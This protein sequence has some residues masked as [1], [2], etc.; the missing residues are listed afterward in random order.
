MKHNEKGINMNVK[1]YCDQQLDELLSFAVIISLYDGK[2]VFC[3]HKQRTTYEIPGGH[4]EKGESI[5]QTAERELKEETGARKFDLEYLCDYSVETSESLNYGR[6][7]A[8]NIME[9]GKLPESEIGEVIIT[10]HLPNNWTY[11]E[12]Q[13]KFIECYEKNMKERIK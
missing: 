3:R 2:Y 4:R 9:L 7:F 6:V 8:A 13:P 12:I 10:E 11:S 5:I 1:I